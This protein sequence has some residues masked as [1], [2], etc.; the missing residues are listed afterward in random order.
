MPMEGGFVLVGNHYSVWSLVIRD[1]RLTQAVKG[2]GV[3][4]GY[5]SRDKISQAPG[6]AD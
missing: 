2:A 1:A 5:G 3:V 4:E 6:T